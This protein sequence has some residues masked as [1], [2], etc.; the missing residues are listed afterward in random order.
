MICI[1]HVAINNAHVHIPVHVFNK[2]R[3]VCLNLTTTVAQVVTIHVQII[4]QRFTALNWMDGLKFFA[5]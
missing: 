5:F 1:V 3:L 2:Q 4:N